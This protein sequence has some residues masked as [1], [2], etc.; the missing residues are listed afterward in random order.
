MKSQRVTIQ[1]KAI[2]QYFPVVM[3]ILLHKVVLTFE[4]VEMRA[5]EHYFPVVSARAN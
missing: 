1:M 4:F 2:D 3:S 5:T